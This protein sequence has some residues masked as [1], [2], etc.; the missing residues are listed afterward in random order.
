MKTQLTW[1]LV[2]GFLAGLNSQ[3]LVAGVSSNAGKL[4]ITEVALKASSDWVELFVVDGT[5]DWS[6][7]RLHKG[8][9]T[10]AF[11][12]PSAWISN[13]LT[14]GDYI[15]IHAESGTDDVQKSNNN[16]GY[17]DG[18]GMGG[19]TGTDYIIQIKEPSGSTARVDAVIWSNDNGSFS[20]SVAQANDAVSD[21]MWNSYD[22]NTGD[23]GAWIDSDDIGSSHSL[24][25]YLNQSGT[26]YIDNNSKGDWYKSGSPTSGST[27]DTS[28]PVTLSSFSALVSGE[29]II[30]YWSTESEVETQ[31]FHILRSENGEG[32]YERISTT[33][34]PSQGN[35][36]MGK[37]Y[38]FYDRNV[39]K[40]KGYWY[41]LE[42][43]STSGVAQIF[44]PVHAL[45]ENDSWTPDESGLYC[46][47]PNPFNSLT[48]IWYRVSEEDALYQISLRIF[49]LM[50]QEVVTLVNQVQEPGEYSVGWDGCDRNDNEVPSGIYFYQ[51]LSGG[52]MLETTRM[53][54]TN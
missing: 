22:F 38:K 6:G 50:G 14:T 36:S 51:L 35:S 20:S 17:W 37:D 26:A 23:A 16:A 15:V 29:T 46:N 32:P 7:Y 8:A 54:K 52:Q 34:I 42:E 41:K 44:G 48:T 9:S 13:G 30:V 39:I 1:I 33:L 24:A 21:G 27:N 3:P 11:T 25:R 43:I 49:N 5:V 10:Y 47:Y 53:L 4:I 2:L 19:L 45:P 18:Y 28:L 40:G 12:I 31:G